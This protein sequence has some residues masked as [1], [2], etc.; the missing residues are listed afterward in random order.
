MQKSARIAEISTKDTGGYFVMFNPVYVQQSTAGCIF[1]IS[2][3]STDMSRLCRCKETSHNVLPDE[4]DNDYDEQ[5]QQN[6]GQN[7]EQYCP[8][9]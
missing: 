7:D 6:D 4:D 1:H 2:T 8:P 3:M 5:Y 9:W